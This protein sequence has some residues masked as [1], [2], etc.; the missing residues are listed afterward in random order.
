MEAIVHVE[1]HVSLNDVIQQTCGVFSVKYWCSSK[2]LH[3]Q[4]KVVCFS[5]HD[6]MCVSS[7]E[8]MRAR[9]PRQLEKSQRNHSLLQTLIQPSSCHHYRCA[10]AH[11]RMIFTCATRTAISFRGNPDEAMLACLALLAVATYSLGK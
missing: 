9:A 4:T 5:L 7:A 11:A 8:E 3:T 2:I 10:L 6:V 1:V